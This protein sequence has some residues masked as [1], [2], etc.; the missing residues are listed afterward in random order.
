VPRSATIHQPTPA[1]AST[2]S[3]TTPPHTRGFVRAGPE[4]S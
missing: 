1:S 4:V 2:S 3:A